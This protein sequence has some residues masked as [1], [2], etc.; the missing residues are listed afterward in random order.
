MER[1][2]KRT[3]Q[4]ECGEEERNTPRNQCG[5]AENTTV[6][7]LNTLLYVC[8][9]T[10]TIVCVWVNIYNCMCVGLH[11]QLYVWV[12]MLCMCGLT[13]SVCVGC[14]LTDGLSMLG[15]NTVPRLVV[16]ILFS[17]LFNCT[18]CK[19]FLHQ[20]RINTSIHT[21]QY[22]S[23]KYVNSNCVVTYCAIVV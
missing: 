14:V 2:V 13:C 7:G 5:R 4:N 8:G 10:Y 11:I 16:V 15:P 21:V 18:S 20:A 1:E 9:L 22:T 12:N 23:D 19:N 17:S 6:Y 3:S